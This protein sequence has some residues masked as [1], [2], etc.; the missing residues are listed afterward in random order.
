MLK[1]VAMLSRVSWDGAGVLCGFDRGAVFE[2]DFPGDAVEGHYCRRSQQG[3]GGHEV[4]MERRDY[5]E[6]GYR[7]PNGPSSR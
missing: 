7:T 1:A 4:I 2:V 6:C 3:E 5:A